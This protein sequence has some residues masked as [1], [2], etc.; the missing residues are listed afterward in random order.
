MKNF[1]FEEV[2]YIIKDD[3]YGSI[4]RCGDSFYSSGDFIE[5][6]WYYSV[7]REDAFISTMTTGNRRIIQAAISHLNNINNI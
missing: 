3:V 6:V 1:K 4:E 5:G 2:D 7:Y